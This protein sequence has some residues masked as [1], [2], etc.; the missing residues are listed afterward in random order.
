MGG[1][2]A[3]RDD[4]VKDVLAIFGRDDVRWHDLYHVFEIVEADVG[5]RMHEEGWTTR[6]AAGR[7]TQTANSRGALGREARHGRDAVPPPAN[8][9]TLVAARTLVRGIVRRWLRDKAE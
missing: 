3:C 6:A 7:F 2:R 4:D 8:P 5:G 9:L 1:P